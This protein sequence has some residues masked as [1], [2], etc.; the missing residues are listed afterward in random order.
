MIEPRSGS[1]MIAP[2]SSR[3][4]HNSTPLNWKTCQVGDPKFSNI[5]KR[6]V[7]SNLVIEKNARETK[8]SESMLEIGAKLLNPSQNF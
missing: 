1:P 4:G 2:N 7:H 3:V 5:E 8:R 6:L